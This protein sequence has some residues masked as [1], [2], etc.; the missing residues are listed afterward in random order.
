M[1]ARSSTSRHS[2]GRCCP[3]ETGCSRGQSGQ[4]R[5]FMPYRAEPD[6]RAAL[7]DLGLDADCDLRDDEPARSAISPVVRGRR[8]RRAR[9]STGSRMPWHGCASLAAA[10]CSGF[11]SSRRWR[12]PTGRRGA[13]ARR[14]L[15]QHADPSLLGE[16]ARR[17]RA[18]ASRLIGRHEVIRQTVSR[19]RP[20]RPGGLLHRVQRKGL[21][22]RIFLR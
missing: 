8:A 10:A 1:S 6:R 22:H 17:H 21:A 15:R 16:R 7:A 9:R 13:H 19:T 2:S 3:C 20:L 11:Q 12:A 18:F 5:L 14:E 4:W